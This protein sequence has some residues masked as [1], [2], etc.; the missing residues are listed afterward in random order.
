[1]T[2]MPPYKL[3][4]RHRKGDELLN[5]LHRNPRAENCHVS[6]DG[7]TLDQAAGLEVIKNGT[8]RYC[9]DCYRLAFLSLTR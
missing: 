5:V 3:Q 4:L 7:L 2:D 6:E 1:M 9:S 8:A